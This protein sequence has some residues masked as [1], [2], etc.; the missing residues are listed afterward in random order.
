MGTR[1]P[2]DSLGSKEKRIMDSNPQKLS[3]QM[4]QQ[5]GENL[6]EQ[7]ENLIWALLDDEIETAD[8]KQLEGLL[9]DDETVRE[10]YVECVQMHTDLH[11][12]FGAP[13]EETKAS[14]LPKS[15][16]LGMLGDLRP[17]TDTLPIPE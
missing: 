13:L 4:S 2:G 14:D 16:V 7:A 9:R 1:V 15:P 8:L 5:P 17:G 3:E 6:L 12:H 11:Q 10:R